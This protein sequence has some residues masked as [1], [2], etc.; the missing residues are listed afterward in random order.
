MN[1]FLKIIIALSIPVAIWKL[2]KRKDEKKE[3]LKN[4]YNL[5]I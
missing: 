5:F 2:S 3:I 4:E 1:N